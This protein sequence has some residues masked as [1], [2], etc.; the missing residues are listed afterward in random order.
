MIGNLCLLEK[1]INNDIPNT[2][3]AKKE[4]YQNCAWQSTRDIFEEASTQWGA[5]EIQERAEKLAQIA[6]EIWK[7]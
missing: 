4:A 1:R 3:E 5:N 2:F 6:V 7:V